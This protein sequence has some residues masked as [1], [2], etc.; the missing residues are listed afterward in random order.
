MEGGG[1]TRGGKESTPWTL[2]SCQDLAHDQEQQKL[3]ECQWLN[4]ASLISELEARHSVSL[5]LH[6][7]CSQGLGGGASV[8]VLS[9]S[10]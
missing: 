3:Q 5:S 9:G 1:E 8:P 7:A 6:L 10:Q 4:P 2:L